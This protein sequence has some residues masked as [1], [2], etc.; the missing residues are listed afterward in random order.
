MRVLIATIGK[1]F[2]VRGEVTVRS[3][4]DEPE[5]RLA[6]GGEVVVDDDDQWTLEIEA[7]RMSALG[8]V[9]KFSGV[10]NREQSEDLRGHEIWAEV[11]SDR[12]AAGTDEWYDHQ[13]VGLPCYSPEN[14]L[15]GSI[16]EVAHQPAH[17]SLVVRTESGDRFVPLVSAIV[18]EVT[19]ERVV[20]DAPGGLLKDD[21]PKEK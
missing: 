18:T 4:T 17:D 3:R 9:V 16:V 21:D 2:G 19:S 11:D 12:V 10:S 6:V 13:L 8:G 14:E 1:P 15:L 7:A 20:I 5:L